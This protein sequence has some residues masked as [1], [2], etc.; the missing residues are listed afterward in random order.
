MQT[1]TMIIITMLFIITV[2]LGG[3]IAIT[4]IDQREKR[5]Q[6]S[7]YVEYISDCKN[8]SIP[9]TADCIRD[10]IMTF[11]NYTIRDE[12]EFSLEDIKSNG[13]DCYNYALL[14][15][16]LAEALGVNTDTQANG[17]I[18]DEYGYVV[19]G[20][21][22]AIIWDNETFCQIDVTDYDP[23]RQVECGERKEFKE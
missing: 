19:T 15:E 14:I 5:E 10:Y 16:N 18:I 22:W 23:R 8:L 2:L 3:S 17:P 13:G 12:K 7:R 1:S 6:D 11:Y 20:H 9:D 21:R 4:Y